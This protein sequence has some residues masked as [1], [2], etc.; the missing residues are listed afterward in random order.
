MAAR[1]PTKKGKKQTGSVY[2]SLIVT[3][4]VAAGLVFAVPTMLVLAVGLLPT[5]V[6]L[7]VDLHPRKF[8]A[9]S[10]GF[11][12]SAGLM[13]YLGDLW[14]KNNTIVGAVGVLTDVMAWLVIYGAAAVGWMVYKGMPVVGALLLEIKI[15]GQIRRLKAERQTL[16]HEWGREPADGQGG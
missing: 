6:A 8:A 10:V 12:N 2:S 15:K 7:L 11:F 5:L 1:K 9:W 16:I 4:A 13:P 3:A 14:I